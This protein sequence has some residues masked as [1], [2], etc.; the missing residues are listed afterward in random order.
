MEDVILVNVHPDQLIPGCVL[1]R[2][3][4]GKSRHPIIEK[5]TVINK[6]HIFVLQHFGI[7]TVEVSDKLADGTAFKP[8]PR[9]RKKNQ[10]TKPLPVSFDELYVQA[11]QGYKEN[12][13]KWQGG[14]EID[15]YS[16]K[17]MLRP[18]FERV[19]N[20]NLDL[21]VLHKY[22][23]ARDYFYYHA[24][25][26]ALLSIFIGKR[27]GYA[28]KDLIDIGLA[29]I[30]ADCGMTK[31][32]ENLYKT[33]KRLSKTEFEEIKKHPAYSYRMVD[34]IL[35]FTREMKL[36]ILQHHERIDGSGYPLGVRE[37]KIHPFAKILAISDTYHAMSS[38]R[39]YQRRQSPFKVLEEML[40]DKHNKLD[41]PLL[42]TFTD[43]LL[44]YSI[45]THVLLS[46]GEEATIIFV[47]EQQPARPFIRLENTREIV[48]L[49]DQ[50]SLYIKDIIES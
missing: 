19:I 14:S 9:N 1:L 43:S 24:V 48:D 41:Y 26:I 7:N 50:P 29:G 15:F 10:K 42:K 16:I 34:G 27:A 31:I 23:S 21:F 40:E 22:A 37:E 28:K 49:T 44:N 36:G 25:A 4:T 35:S 5:N 17:K 2:Q 45:G 38:E 13:L 46:T 12:F 6:Q 30:F 8:A 11:V 47:N 32:Q 20:Q 39:L 3:V 18:L 33:D